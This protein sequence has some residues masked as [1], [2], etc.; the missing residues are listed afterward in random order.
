MIT[1]VVW[2]VANV[3]ERMRKQ[4]FFL[5]EWLQTIAGTFAKSANVPAIAE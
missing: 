1:D 4:N 3:G 5:S 2:D